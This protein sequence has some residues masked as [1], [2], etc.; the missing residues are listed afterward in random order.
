MA[1]FADSTLPGLLTGSCAGVT[2]LDA[3]AT[4]ALLATRALVVPRRMTAGFVR[5]ASDVLNADLLLA[6]TVLGLI[7]DQRDNFGG[8]MSF[9]AGDY[10]DETA[11]IYVE[12]WSLRSGDRVLAVARKRASTKSWTNDPKS[13]FE[14]AA[15]DAIGVFASICQRGAAPAG[16]SA[17]PQDDP[18]G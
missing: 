18:R 13:L 16:T 10:D 5:Q 12:G 6:P 3:R 4:E 14:G 9:I 2:V 11:G 1:L 15:R 7:Q 17:P 8:F